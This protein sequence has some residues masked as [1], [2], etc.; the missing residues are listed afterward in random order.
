MGMLAVP[1][2]GQY[3]CVTAGDQNHCQGAVDFCCVRFSGYHAQPP[4]AYK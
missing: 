2:C 3:T 4:L 1:R